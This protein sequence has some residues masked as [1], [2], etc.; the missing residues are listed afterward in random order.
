M[1]E[2][3][4]QKRASNATVNELAVPPPPPPPPAWTDE[5]RTRAAPPEEPSPARAAEEDEPEPEPRTALERLPRSEP[6][7]RP[8]RMDLMGTIPHADGPAHL[9]QPDEEAAQ[10]EHTYAP[11]ERASTPRARPTS[12]SDHLPSSSSI[13]TSRPPRRRAP[14]PP[15]QEEEVS[16]FDDS[17]F[18]L[19]T[20]PMRVA[21]TAEPAEDTNETLIP[22]D[23]ESPA[24]T[25]SPTF[26]VTPPGKS[27][28]LLVVLAVVMLLLGTL[29]AVVGLGLD[30]GR[31][32]GLLG[33]NA[34]PPS[35]DR[36]RLEPLKG[37]DKR[38]QP[39]AAPAPAQ[40][41]ESKPA[42]AAPP[43]PATTGSAAPSTTPEPPKPAGMAPPAIPSGTPPPDTQPPP[44]AVTA[45]APAGK[46]P[47]V[48]PAAPEEEPAQPVKKP[49]PPS[50]RTHRD[51]KT[52]AGGEGEDGSS[53]D[54][55]ASAAP[56]GSG[57]LTLVTTPYAKV[58]L[59]RRYLGDTPLFKIS[60]PSG[61]HSLK[62]VGADGRSLRT[63]VEIKPGETTALKLAL[64]QLDPG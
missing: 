59:G 29:G 13:S 44:P 7:S 30:G 40:A 21:T 5:N 26:A 52:A 45:S 37:P 50:K 32:G 9:A 58:Y 60:L 25:T 53:D 14:T 49:H 17:L 16:P 12:S 56:S 8:M 4:P 35:P 31:L 64:D 24:V 43:A 48:T 42:A 27:G 36:G 15:P 57:T 39:T 61:K 55:P 1:F 54:E 38:A 63:P 47:S 10:E 51:S 46:A 6:A 34:P 62:L 28:G 11:A 41:P 2:P 18:E 23:E 19:K 3:L 22:E 33:L 20:R